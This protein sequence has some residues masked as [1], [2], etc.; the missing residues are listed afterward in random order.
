MGRFY[1]ATDAESEPLMGEQIRRLAINDFRKTG[2]KQLLIVNV[3]HSN[4]NRP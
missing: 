2:E 3:S 4:M 1:I